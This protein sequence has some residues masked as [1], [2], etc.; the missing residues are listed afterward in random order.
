MNKKHRKAIIYDLEKETEEYSSELLIDLN[1]R[2]E[3]VENLLYKILIGSHH[4]TDWADMVAHN[5]EAIY[6]FIEENKKK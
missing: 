1:E 3:R 5:E 6:R 2:L 4:Y